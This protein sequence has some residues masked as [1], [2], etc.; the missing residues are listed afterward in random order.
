MDMDSVQKGV[1]NL[2]KTISLLQDL[3]L[4]SLGSNKVAN[5]TNTY[6]PRPLYRH[7]ED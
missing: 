7:F 5:N 6:Q 1:T 2:Q 3:G 4:A